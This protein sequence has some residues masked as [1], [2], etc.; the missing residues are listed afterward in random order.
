MEETHHCDLCPHPADLNVLRP[1]GENLQ[2]APWTTLKCLHRYHTHCFLA[3]IYDIDNHFT[4]MFCPQCR[5]PLL[6][7]EVRQRIMQNRD[8]DAYDLNVR[9]RVD[10]LWATNETFREDVKELKTLQLN[11]LK[12]HR[13]TSRDGAVLKREWRELVHP[14]VV[15]LQTQKRTF[16]RRFRN[17]ESRA[18]ALRSYNKYERKR[19][20]IRETYETGVWDLALLRNI[21]GAPKIMDRFMPYRYEHYRNFRI[22]I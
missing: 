11:A 4:E 6:H 15:Y 18:P 9:R 13:L 12:Q 19:R 21:P 10:N 2:A 1:Y 14:S 22:R 20:Q 3:F 8:H 16:L 17:L 5:D 7:T